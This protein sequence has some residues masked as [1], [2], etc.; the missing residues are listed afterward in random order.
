MTALALA[1]ALPFGA[2]RV[3]AQDAG[4]VECP[5]PTP[6]IEEVFP[7]VGAREVTL[8]APLRVRYTPD[9]FGPT[10]PGGDPTTMLSVHRC[11]GTLTCDLS[12][13][14]EEGPAVAG[15]VQIVGDEIVFFPDGAQWD[16]ETA[17]GGI[18]RSVFGDL[19]F[20]FCTGT[21]EDDA[22]PR[23]GSI[24]DLTS[25]AIEPRCDAPDGG[26][27]VGVFFDPATDVAAP[28]GSIEYLVY[29]TRGPGID[30]PVV[31]SRARNFTTGGGIAM[32]FV[33]PPD[34]ATGTICVRVAAVDGVGN[35]TFDGEPGDPAQCVDPVQGNFFYGL[36][37]VGAPGAPRGAAGGLAAMGL[38]TLLLVL[39]RRA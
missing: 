1:L 16:P 20:N 36:C 23:F 26:F 19:Q 8:D 32:G 17:Y 4:M 24:T 37:A 5:D 3:A 12:S 2:G 6:Q 21:A 14:T 25:D 29:Q 28:P 39:R 31:R 18:A 30:G 7:T 35:V 13:C 9:Y 22:P 27:R 11:T 33:L 15:R 10:G 34:E 38:V